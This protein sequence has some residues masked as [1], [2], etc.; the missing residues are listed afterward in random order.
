MITSNIAI[1]TPCAARF[2]LS[3]RL[4]HIDTE[5]SVLILGMGADRAYTPAFVEGATGVRAWSPPV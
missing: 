3:V 4:S 2:R 1:A 5:K